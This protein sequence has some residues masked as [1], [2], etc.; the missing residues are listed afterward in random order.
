MT[1]W[2]SDQVLCDIT[3]LYEVVTSYNEE[4]F[5][6]LKQSQN[7][8]NLKQPEIFGTSRELGFNRL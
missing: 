5:V 7:H 4:V 3:S 2:A 1:L 8:M 6:Y